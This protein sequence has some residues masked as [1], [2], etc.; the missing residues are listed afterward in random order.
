[1][2]PSSPVLG[3]SVEQSARNGPPAHWLEYIARKAPHLL[4]REGALGPG[5]SSFA[6]PRHPA[7]IPTAQAEAEG[8]PALQ[9]EEAKHSLVLEPGTSATRR[10]HEHPADSA[11]PPR[12]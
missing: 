10:P 6:R 2:S 9:A 11:A 4:T 7:A 3:H 1:A 5:W 8:P 12:A